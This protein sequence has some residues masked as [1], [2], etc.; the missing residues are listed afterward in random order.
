M[1]QAQEVSNPTQEE[2]QPTPRPAS[3]RPDLRER[4]RHFPSTYGLIAFTALVF[5]AQ[6]VSVR[7]LGID[8]IIALGAKERE[9]IVAGQVWRVITPLFVHVGL[10]HVFVN[11]YSLFALGPAVERFLSSKRMLAVYLLSGMSGVMFSLAFSSHPSVGASGAI[12]GMLGALAAFLFRHRD[13]FGRAGMLQFRHL[14]IVALLNLGLGLLPGI[15][16]WGHVGGLVAGGVLTWFFGPR[17]EAVWMEGGRGQLV[18]KY[19]WSQASRSIFIVGFL[20][21]A[22]ALLAAFSSVG[23]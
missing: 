7:L 1:T 23:S 15:D 13:L 10:W 2:P 12:F 22:L 5:L 21:A 14:A 4:I 17:M 20:L 19:E 9:A 18:D 8:I 11:M 16:N 3:R 6:T